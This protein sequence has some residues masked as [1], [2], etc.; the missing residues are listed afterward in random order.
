VLGHEPQQH[1]FA[2]TSVGD[3]N[4]RRGPDAQNSVKDGAAE[5]DKIGAV[6]ANAGVERAFV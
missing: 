4:A 6:L 2:Q 3:A 1:A 5:D